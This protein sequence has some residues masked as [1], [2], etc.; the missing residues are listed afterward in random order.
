MMATAQTMAWTLGAVLE[1][2]L[3]EAG[4]PDSLRTVPVQG[5]SLN[6]AQI[7]PGDVFIA[8]QGS[9]QHG[10]AFAEQA[11]ARGAAAILWEIPADGV[12]PIQ[13]A[14]LRIPA[15]GIPQLRSLLGW[16]ASRIQQQP[17][18]QLAI[19]A[20]T[21]T[22]GKTSVAHLLTQAW[23]LLGQSAAQIGTLGMGPLAQ[24]RDVG[25][26]TPDSLLL[27][28]G[29][30]GFVEAG[31][32]RVAM[33][34]SSHALDQGR[35]HGTQ[36]QQAIFTGLA[37]DHMDYHAD[38]AA[39]AAAKQRLFAWPGLQ[40]AILCGGN[41][42]SERWAALLGADVACVRY[43]LDASCE[44]WARPLM[45]QAQGVQ[46]LRFALD[47]V[48]GRGQVQS[49]L[50][51]DFNLYN[52]LAVFAALRMQEVSLADACAV[53]HELE[54]VPGRMQWLR[55]A[56]QAAVVIDYAHTPQ[57]LE[58]VLRSLRATHPGRVHLVFGCGG[59]RD[60]GKRP[61]MAAVAERFAD[62]IWLTNDNPR[63]EDPQT[64]VAEIRAGLRQPAG[65]RVELDRAAAIAA[66]IHAA[67]AEDLVLIA[68][69]G[70]ETTQQIGAQYLPFS[71]L[72]AVRGALGLHG[73]AA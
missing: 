44:V 59:E 35:L 63:N 62:Q 2:L 70:H 7:H 25:M 69:K 16:L 14:S 51:G 37:R 32:Q 57:A 5:L 33:E 42:W 23:G 40:Q 26:T 68:G 3:P 73:G 36:I 17:S 8:L 56:D 55:A 30:R 11:T 72:A 43:G 39:Y 18:T 9:K 61:L 10:L 29:L 28:Q 6:A 12:T 60:R 45:E 71:D 27:Q 49:R 38:E 52:L 31:V 41:V 46:P 65:V 47:G 58:A 34:A 66:A 1:G 4:L 24:L 54:P 15:A 64:I 67:D 21:G 48:L 50:L 19:T 53:L 22:D 20:V 13:A